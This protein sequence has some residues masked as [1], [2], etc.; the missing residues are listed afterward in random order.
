[1]RLCILSDA[2]EDSQ[3]PLKAVDL[4]CDP[5]PYFA[6]HECHRVVLKKATAIQDVIRLAREG[7]DVFVNLCDG[8]WDED[9]PG[10]EVVQA[11]E[12]LGQAFTGATSSFYEPSREAMKRVCHAWG[13]RTPAGLEVTDA[14]GIE[15]AGETLRFPLIVKHPSSYSSI[16]MT[17]ESRVESPAELAR[18]ARRMIDSY[19]GALVEE[20]IEGRELSVLVAENPDDPASPTVYEPVEI[21]FPPGETFKHFAVKWIDYLGMDCVPVEDRDLAGRAK[22]AC[23]RLFVGLGGA[24]YG[25]CDLRVDARGEVYVLEINANCGVFYPMDDPGTADLIL[26]H[27]PGGHRAFAE[28]ILQAAV[29]RR[30]RRRPRW[31]VRSDREGNYSTVAVRPI[32]AGERIEAHEGAA[33]HLVTRGHVEACWGPVERAWFEGYAWP[34][35]DEVWVTWSPDPEAWKPI[36][37]SCD[38]SAWLEGLDVVARRDLEPGDEVTLDYATFC[39]EPMRSFECA[40]GAARCRGEI[41][42]TDYLEDF[43]ERYGD[44]LSPY[45]RARRDEALAAGERLRKAERR[46]QFR[47]P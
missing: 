1:M 42:G 36:N 23:R 16:G 3:S 28:Q 18:Q 40:C 15:R 45:V 13:V 25:R 5:T 12:R 9:R 35:S 37:H 46:R 22:E 27:A 7:F 20:F 44:H 2:Y 47:R 10:I 24:S 38:P 30:E 31:E 6:E 43:V 26:D 41:R 17:R 39:T 4:P 19:G 34:L 32:R 29:A 11:L 8:A 14:A 33:H 21:T